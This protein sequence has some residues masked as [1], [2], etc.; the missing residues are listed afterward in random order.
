[1]RPPPHPPSSPPPPPYPTSPTPPPPPPP[2]RPPP[3]PPA[4][5][6][7]AGILRGARRTVRSS[8]PPALLPRQCHAA[9]PSEIRH[10]AAVVCC[11]LA[12]PPP[13]GMTRL[14]TEKQLAALPA[15]PTPAA[16]SLLVPARFFSDCRGATSEGCSTEGP[17]A[18]EPL[19]K[20]C[21]SRTGPWRRRAAG[22]GNRLK[23]QCWFLSSKGAAEDAHKRQLHY[24]SPKPARRRP[25][26]SEECVRACSSVQTIQTRVDIQRFA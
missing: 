23:G 15:P 4:W 14:A 3:P 12:P 11:R 20:A 24:R 17:Q 9:P 1:M 7:R 19:D 26:G 10:A 2:P 5:S 6:Y 21:S 22:Q 8:R 16:P 25:L 13:H 18:K